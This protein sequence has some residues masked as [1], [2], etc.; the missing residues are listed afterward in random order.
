MTDEEAKENDQPP[1]VEIIDPTKNVYTLELKYRRMYPIIV[2]F[3][4]L[5][6]IFNSVVSQLIL[7][8]DLTPLVLLREKT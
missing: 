6:V 5:P 1:Q 2:S 4:V 3:Q 7:M 8:K